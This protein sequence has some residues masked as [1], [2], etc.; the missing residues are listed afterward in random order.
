MRPAREGGIPVRVKNSYNP[1]APGTIITKTR[2][3]TKVYSLLIFVCLHAIIITKQN[4]MLLH[5]T[6][7]FNEHCSETQ[8][9]HAGYSKHPN[10]WS[11][12]ISC[13]G[14]NIYLQRIYV[15]NVSVHQLLVQGPNCALLHSF[16]QVFSIFED[17]EISVD[18]V[19]TS[20]VSISLTLD[21]SKLWSRELI[22]QA[23][24]C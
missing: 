22:Q 20:E 6:D 9:D 24:S 21:P 15:A 7:S 12:R 3:M 5:M 18:V 10:A 16:G 4:V 14:N 19:A 23:S 11:S 8:C 1:K 2:D 17:L 13:Q